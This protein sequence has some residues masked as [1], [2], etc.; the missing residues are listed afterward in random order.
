VSSQLA[1]QA[2]ISFCKCRNEIYVKYFSRLNLI[3]VYI[4]ALIGIAGLCVSTAF[5]Y[6]H[7]LLQVSQGCFQGKGVPTESRLIAVQFRIS[8]SVTRHTL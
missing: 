2:L 3:H 4:T 1:W 8:S 7:A 6:T 5:Q